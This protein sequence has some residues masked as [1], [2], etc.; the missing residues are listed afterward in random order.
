MYRRLTKILDAIFLFWEMV[1]LELSLMG[2]KCKK[3]LSLCPARS[4]F[5]PEAVVVGRAEVGELPG[6][7]S[8]DGRLTRKTLWAQKRLFHQSLWP[9]WDTIKHSVRQFNPG[10]NTYQIVSL[11]QAII[12]VQSYW[13]S[14]G[15][16]QRLHFPVLLLVLNQLEPFSSMI[17]NPDGGKDRF[18]LGG[19]PINSVPPNSPRFPFNVSTFIKLNLNCI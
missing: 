19:Q 6:S 16:E 3:H 7:T 15:Q 5:C 12:T 4:P 1:A 2:L 11:L 17:S 14:P 8:S 10:N 9:K 18:G 13:Q